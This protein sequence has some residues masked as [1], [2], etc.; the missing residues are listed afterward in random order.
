MIKDILL[1]VIG[2]FVG[3]ISTRIQKRLDKKENYIFTS[4]ESMRL[5]TKDGDLYNPV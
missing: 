4:E 1:V 3:F 2:A 5:K